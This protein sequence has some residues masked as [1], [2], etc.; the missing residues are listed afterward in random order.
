MCLQKTP[1]AFLVLLCRREGI[2][3]T[4]LV[5]KEKASLKTYTQQVPE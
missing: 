5:D 3:K 2:I 1:D 4:I